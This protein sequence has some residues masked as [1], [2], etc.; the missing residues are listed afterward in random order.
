MSSVR[1]TS[2]MAL[3][4]AWLAYQEE[5]DSHCSPQKRASR[6]TLHKSASD[7]IVK[8][9]QAK[10]LPFCLQIWKHNENS[11]KTSEMIDYLGGLCYLA[12]GSSQWECVCLEQYFN[13]ISQVQSKWDSV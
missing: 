11:T 1:G 4:A 9:L 10:C 5:F 13:S 7:A 3:D 6:K 12:S 2:R 8:A